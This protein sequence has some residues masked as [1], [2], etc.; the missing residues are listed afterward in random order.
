MDPIQYIYTSISRLRI[1]KTVTKPTHTAMSKKTVLITGC[2]EGGIGAAL[3]KAFHAK[4]YHVYA[5]LR[6]TSKAGSLE[7]IDGIEISTLDVTKQDSIERCVQEIKTKSGGTLDVLVN[8]AGAD[9][10]MPL[11]DVS[12]EEAKALYD[13]NV[14]GVL[15][16]TQAFAPMLIKA[17]GTLVNINSVAAQMILAWGGECMSTVGGA[18]PYKI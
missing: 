2:S 4:G 5:T 8:N 17:R 6:N 10:T 1:Q 18:G 11:L 9:C 3:A 14:W 12:L 13:L 7:N 15:A 16:V